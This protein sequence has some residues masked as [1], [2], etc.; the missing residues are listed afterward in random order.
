MPVQQTTVKPLIM[1]SKGSMQPRPVKLLLT[2]TF[3]DLELI[4]EGSLYAIDLETDGTVIHP[5][6]IQMVSLANG[7][8][9]IAYNLVGGSAG[10]TKRFWHKISTLKLMA[11][12][13]IF[14]AAWCGAAAGQSITDLKSQ[15]QVCLYVYT[16]LLCADQNMH[17]IS[18]GWAQEHILGWDGAAGQKE[19]LTA[20]L[21]E[22]G[23]RKDQMSQLA[24]LE[25]EGYLRYNGMDADGC[26]QLHQYYEQLLQQHPH[27]RSIGTWAQVHLQEIWLLIE[28]EQRGMYA[29]KWE[30]QAYH[31]DLCQRVEAHRTEFVESKEV[32][33][34]EASRYQ[35]MVSTH[36]AKEP[37]R[38]TKANK[39]SKRWDQWQA[40]FNGFM[41]SAHLNINSGPQLKDL[42]YT[43]LGFTPTRYSEKTRQPQ[44]DKQLLPTMG[45]LGKLLFRYRKLAKEEGYV[46]AAVGKSIDDVIHP[47]FIPH[48]TLTGRLAGAGGFNL[49]QQPKV[50]DYLKIFR[51]RPGY[52]IVHLDYSA[53]E[54]AVLCEASRDAAL[55]SVYGPNAGPNDIYLLFGSN[56]RLPFAAK[57]KR[58]YDPDNPTAAGIAN[59]KK[60]CK[61][62][63]GVCKEI[64]L[65]KQ[66]NAGV[67]RCWVSLVE[68]EIDITKEEVAIICKGWDEQFKG[69]KQF[70]RQLEAERTQ[71]GGWIY[72]GVGRPIPIGEDKVKDII[73]T[74]CQS[75]G[76]DLLIWQLSLVAAQRD[77]QGIEMH[78]WICD[79]HDELMFE[80][81]EHQVEAACGIFR[82][83][84]QQINDALPWEV[85]IKG[86]PG[87]ATNLAQ[88]KLED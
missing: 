82:Q 44:L 27:L 83:T 64:H 35:D 19:W 6:R 9:V 61:W 7:S 33:Q 12:N 15:W 86:E 55:W 45:E 26:W 74:Y 66:Y 57:I 77:M 80:V 68:K 69:I 18:L 71:R 36:K 70:G 21:K 22:H 10:F 13:A 41:E 79:Y 88:I 34:Y 40:K 84:L 56:P 73:N 20:K 65:A 5:D 30:L 87:V 25:T 76:H 48:G 54:P 2:P 46:R 75:T 31:E 47:A 52:R 63:R 78:P 59:A 24:H 39:P 11:F 14:D 4:N 23:L 37:P 8:G 29:P 72:N 60:H 53:V 28:Q 38:Y 1:L 50:E 67:H 3:A 81:P 62:E 49:Q 17:D 43:Q 32:K 42:F 51:A 16:K 85:T 58:W